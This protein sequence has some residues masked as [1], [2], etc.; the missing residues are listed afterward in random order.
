MRVRSPS[1]HLDVDDHGVARL[2]IRDV[3]AGGELVALLLLD[4]LNDV[5]GEFSVGCAPPRLREMAKC[6]GRAGF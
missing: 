3:L 5:H 1:T 4:L 2:E 6:L